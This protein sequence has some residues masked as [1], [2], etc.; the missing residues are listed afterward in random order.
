MEQLKGVLFDL[1]GTLLHSAPDFHSII[2]QMLLQRNLPAIAYTTLEL[3]V[4]NG[5]RAMVSKAFNLKVTDSGFNEL[6]Q[7]MLSRYMQH[8]D[9]DSHLFE[10]I[11]ELL[12]ELEDLDIKWGIVTNKPL[13]YTTEILKSFKLD[14][15]A[16]S[17]ICPDH[18]TQTKPH[19]EPLILA[20]SQMSISP[21]HCIYVGD[22]LRDIE[23]G[24]AASMPTIGCSYGYVTSHEEALLWNATHTTSS[25]Q[26][27]MSY[28]KGY[29]SN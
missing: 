11:D 18:V 8:L 23:A 20:C 5:A 9:V 17:V 22:H 26:G 27:I 2:N 15:R 16:A 3:E 13:I 7:E 4:S 10:G 6:H 28:L 29:I 14:K 25:P 12:T 19:P 1:D 21:E 24:K